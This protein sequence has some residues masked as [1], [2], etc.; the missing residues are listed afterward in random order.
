[1]KNNLFKIALL[2][3]VTAAFVA[4]PNLVRAAD[5]T[6]TPA[7]T[8]PAHKKNGLPF[9]GKIAA[10]D[11]TAETLTVGSLTIEVTSA[12]KISKDGKK[13]ALADL[14]VG[15]A[16]TGYYKKDDAGKLTATTIHAGK[17]AEKMKPATSSATAPGSN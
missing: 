8:A 14:T 1:M 4:N 13:S 9:H 16:V 3:L 15:E 2:G 17:K 5:S 6:N 12:T 10:V 11:T 7:A